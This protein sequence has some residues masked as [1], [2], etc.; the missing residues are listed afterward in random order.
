MSLFRR[1]SP[2]L[3]A[4]KSKSP[5]TVDKVPILYSEGMGNIDNIFNFKAVLFDPLS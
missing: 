1:G 4:I 5:L 2:L 3:I